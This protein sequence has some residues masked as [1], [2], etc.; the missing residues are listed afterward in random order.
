MVY[1]E[2]LGRY[3]GSVLGIAWSLFNPIFMLL[4]YTFVFSVI[5]KSSWR[6][7]SEGHADFA[8]TLFAGMIVFGLFSE[9]INRAPGLVL[10][11]P[12]YVKKVLFPLE[13]L[14][15]ISLGSGLFHAA[16]SVAILVIFLWL[17]NHTIPSTAL[18]LPI[19]LLPLVLLVL[20]LCWFLAALGVYLRDISQTVG[21][22]TT[23]LMFISPVFYST[24]ALPSDLQ[25]Y[26]SL[27]PLASLLKAQEMCLFLENHR[28]SGR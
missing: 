3:R 5:F 4:I 7:T 11:N 22:L 8:I 2:V 6:S 27:N 16:I 17:L 13:I 10:N 28:I 18:Y 14:P 15:W 19:V 24:E 9:C 1:R 12:N 26:I 21:I 20:G 23:G 25:Q